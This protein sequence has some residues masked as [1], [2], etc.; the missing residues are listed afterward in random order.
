MWV[1]AKVTCSDE[2]Y[3]L[4]HRSAVKYHVAAVDETR[5]L[6]AWVGIGSLPGLVPLLHIQGCEGCV[7]SLLLQC[8]C[9]RLQ[10]WTRSLVWFLVLLQRLASVFPERQSLQ[11]RK[12]PTPA[13]LEG[14][15]KAQ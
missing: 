11:D 5:A 15:S 7:R 1:H 6:W 3:F 9:A 12:G 8:S 4:T 2:S 10:I 13:H 14:R